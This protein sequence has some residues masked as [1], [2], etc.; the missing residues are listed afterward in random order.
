VHSVTGTCIARICMTA[1]VEILC[2]T[3]GRESPFLFAA[4][5][6]ALASLRIESLLPWGF[7]TV[8]LDLASLNLHSF[9]CRRVSSEWFQRISLFPALCNGTCFRGSRSLSTCA[10][11]AGSHISMIGHWTFLV[12]PSFS[13]ISIPRPLQKLCQHC[14]HD[15]RAVSTVTFDRGAQL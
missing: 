1:S 14:F 5:E 12:C 8:W 11:E 2:E 9:F 10:F 7:G 4:F 6:Y 15:C 3:C 13:A